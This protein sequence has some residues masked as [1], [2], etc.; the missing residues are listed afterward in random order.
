MMVVVGHRKFFYWCF[1]QN[2]IMLLMIQIVLGRNGM[3]LG[4]LFGH[5]W[6]CPKCKLLMIPCLHAM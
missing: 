1:I 6:H 4:G 2:V 3:V 5:N